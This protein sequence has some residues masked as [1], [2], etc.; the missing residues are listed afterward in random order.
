[1]VFMI[2]AGT[3]TAIL[4]LWLRPLKAEY[5]LFL[6]LGA[7]LLLVG[8]T[9]TQL[10]EVTSLL[11]RLMEASGL[12]V[13]YYKILLKIMGLAW[14]SQLASDICKEAGSPAISKQIDIY[15]KILILS[16]S[17]PVFQALVT[18]I[19]GLFPLR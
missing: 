13:V 2:L 17:L 4:A 1:M 3:S 15:G 18:T 14:I 12:N 8:A 11:Q 16:I 9:L 7:M 6:S 5:S 19:E 10:K